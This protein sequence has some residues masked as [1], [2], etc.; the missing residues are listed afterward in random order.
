MFIVMWRR[1]G[2]VTACYIREFQSCGVGGTHEGD[3]RC[4]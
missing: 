3:R 2:V 1:D 4:W